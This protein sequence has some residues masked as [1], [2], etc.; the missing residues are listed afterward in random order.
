MAPLGLRRRRPEV[1]PPSSRRPLVSSRLELGST[2][3]A[4]DAGAK[5]DGDQRED[6]AKVAIQAKTLVI[7]GRDLDEL[8]RELSRLLS[9]LE[10]AREWR[11]L[12][13]ETVESQATEIAGQHGQSITVRAYF[14]EGAEG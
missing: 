3:I 13:A 6:M 8:D 14:R 9:G 1:D 11:L 4:S 10:A 2:D 7:N 5:F 12:Q